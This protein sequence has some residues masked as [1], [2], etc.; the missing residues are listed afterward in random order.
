[1]YLNSTKQ[2]SPISFLSKLKFILWLCLFK[3]AFLS[4][5]ILSVFNGWFC[6]L[7]DGD[8][9]D[10]KSCTLKNLTQTGK[11]DTLTDGSRICLLTREFYKLSFAF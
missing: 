2:I 6:F 8:T 9:V 4:S 3:I 11:A 5:N 10:T 1:M 7:T